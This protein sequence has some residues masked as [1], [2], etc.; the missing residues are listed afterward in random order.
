MSIGLGKKASYS[1]DWFF[2]IFL[3]ICLFDF[4]FMTAPVAYGNSQARS[5]IRAAACATA[6]AMPDPSHMCDLHH[7]SRQCGIL[8]PLSEARDGGHVLMDI[9]WV[10][11]HWATT[12]T[13]NILTNLFTV[14]SNHFKDYT[15]PPQF[16][17]WWGGRASIDFGNVDIVLMIRF[18]SQM[19]TFN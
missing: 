17:F 15:P 6:I 14:F 5:R 13:Q 11:Y 19:M 9:S 18:D 10:H 16:Y 3:F 1:V 8:S 4:L 7:S 2:N 12:G